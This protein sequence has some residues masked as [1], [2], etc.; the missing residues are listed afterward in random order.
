MGQGSGLDAEPCERSPQQ[1]IALA[2]LYQSHMALVT[3]P[4]FTHKSTG[5]GLWSLSNSNPVRAL[6]EIAITGT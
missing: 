2:R 1:T 4:F 3:N 5:F 6:I